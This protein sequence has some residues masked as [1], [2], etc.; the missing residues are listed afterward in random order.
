M[1]RSG[2]A[3]LNSFTMDTTTVLAWAGEEQRAQRTQSNTRHK[4]HAIDNKQAD[5]KRA[6]NKQADSKQAH[7][8]FKSISGS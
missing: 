1:L 3:G 2:P 5:N 8:F 6:E 4:Q 7:N